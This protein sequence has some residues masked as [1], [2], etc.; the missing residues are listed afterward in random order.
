MS[1]KLIACIYADKG[2]KQSLYPPCG[3]NAS[4]TDG[5]GKP[6][7]T[8]QWN[9]AKLVLGDIEKYEASIASCTTAKKQVAYANKIK[10]RL[11]V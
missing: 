1:L 3:P 6:K 4:T 5:G 9:L 10:N 11:R 7:V 8:A 2:I